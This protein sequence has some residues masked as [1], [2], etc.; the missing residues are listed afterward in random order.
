MHFGTNTSERA[1]SDYST[2]WAFVALKM[3]EL[4]KYVFID[5]S[6]TYHY[7]LSISH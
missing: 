2:H 4:L 3:D 5:I 7:K 6:Y 1:A